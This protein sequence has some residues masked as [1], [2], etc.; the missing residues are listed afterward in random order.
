MAEFQMLFYNIN[1]GSDALRE[2]HRLSKTWIFLLIPCLTWKC[3]TVNS[4]VSADLTSF[5]GIFMMLSRVLGQGTRVKWREVSPSQS[6]F[7]LGF[8]ACAHAVCGFLMAL[9]PLSFFALAN[10]R[11]LFQ[12]VISINKNWY[13]FIDHIIYENFRIFWVLN[14]LTILLG[15]NVLAHVLNPSHIPMRKRCIFDFATAVS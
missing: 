4:H 6:P 9:L 12:A 11:R 10:P 8:Q 14:I 2:V 3:F 15:R 13:C 5:R 7:L 1:V